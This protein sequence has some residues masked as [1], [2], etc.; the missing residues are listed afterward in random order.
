MRNLSKKKRNRNCSTSIHEQN[1]DME[2]DEEILSIKIM[3]DSENEVLP[4]GSLHFQIER[5]LREDERTPQLLLIKETPAGEYET[6]LLDTEE[7]QVVAVNTEKKQIVSFV[8]D[9]TGYFTAVYKKEETVTADRGNTGRS[10][11]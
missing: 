10:H 1:P 9:R 4:Q 3:D 8:T 5:E 11:H 6:E 7:H 2:T